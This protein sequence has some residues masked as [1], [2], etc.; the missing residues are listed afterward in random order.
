MRPAGKT[1]VESSISSLILRGNEMKATRTISHRTGSI[2]VFARRAIPAALA[3]AKLVGSAFIAGC[4][5][6]DDNG[7]PLIEQPTIGAK[8][9]PLLTVGGYQFKDLNANGKLDPYE[10]W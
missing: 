8:A 9:K 7:G 3:A 5:S 4:G 6:D 1:G 10:D 2:F